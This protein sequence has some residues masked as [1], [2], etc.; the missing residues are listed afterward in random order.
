MALVL[1][2]SSCE[3]CLTINWSDVTGPYAVGTNESGYGSE[4]GVLSPSEFTTYVLQMWF[5]NSDLDGDPDFTYNL[6]LNIPTP[7]PEGHYSWTF[8]AAQ[9]GVP[10]IRSGVY[11]MTA[12]AVL[13]PN[14]YITDVQCIF[15]RDVKTEVI[16][17]AMLNYDPT[18]GCK[19]G[20]VDAAGLFSMYETVACGGIC[21]AEKAQDIIDYLYTQQGCC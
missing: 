10:A 5:P 3:E 21:N 14:T 1:Q 8:T 6:K 11:N 17:P 20:C 4:N 18:C 9:L 12:T 19:D 2:S 13:A 7:D 16:D 15:T